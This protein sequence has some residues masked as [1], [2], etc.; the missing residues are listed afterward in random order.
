MIHSRCAHAE[1]VARTLP[2]D[3]LRVAYRDGAVKASCVCGAQATIAADDVDVLM[4]DV[5]AFLGAHADC[6]LVATRQVPARRRAAQQ[7]L[8]PSRR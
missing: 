7:P 2:P 6:V 1:R 4:W 3:R 5:K 8:V